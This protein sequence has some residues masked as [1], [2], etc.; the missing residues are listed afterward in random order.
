MVNKIGQHGGEE[1]TIST[2]ILSSL[3]LLCVNGAR[4][5]PP[6]F[7]ASTVCSR[8][9]N[10][11]TPNLFTI[12]FH[13][14]IQAKKTND[15]VGGEG[16]G[17]IIA[18]SSTSRE[19]MKISNHHHHHRQILSLTVAGLWE[20]EPTLRPEAAW[21]VFSG[22]VARLLTSDGVGTEGAWPWLTGMETVVV[23]EEK[24]ESVCDEH[25]LVVV[26]LW[27]ALK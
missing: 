20:V 12:S 23:W 11:Y 13:L 16:E 2:F 22:W 14:Y 25:F 8:G 18:T 17:V 24:T 15:K 4:H 10:F 6:N 1:K 19:S 7:I 3:F 5:L 27:G 26:V 21:G 9:Q